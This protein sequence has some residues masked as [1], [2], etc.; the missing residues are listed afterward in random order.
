MS[1]TQ[2][3]V[4]CHDTKHPPGA[5]TDTLTR[6]FSR[7]FGSD[8]TAEAGPPTMS[9]GGGVLGTTRN[10]TDLF[11]KYRNQARGINKFGTDAGPDAGRWAGGLYSS[12][13]QTQDGVEW[14]GRLPASQ[15]LQGS[16][17]KFSCHRLSQHGGA[18]PTAR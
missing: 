18:Q 2:I 4:D 14:C 7:G 8:V 13:A 17:S 12:L 6:T 10:R 15:Q 16:A 11:L 9:V 1:C 5:K 3:W